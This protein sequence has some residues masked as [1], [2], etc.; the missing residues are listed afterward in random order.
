MRR[1]RRRCRRV[2]EKQHDIDLETFCW[3]SRGHCHELMLAYLRNSF[4][5]M[6]WCES[7]IKFFFNC[8]DGSHESWA[9]FQEALSS[10]AREQTRKWTG[11]EQHPPERT[12]Q[13]LSERACANW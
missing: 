5:S 4:R 13:R 1:T 11:K 9:D 2:A 7:F 6:S 10:P 12:S 3:V 8:D